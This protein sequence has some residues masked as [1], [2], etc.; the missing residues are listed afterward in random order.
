MNKK[1]LLAVIALVLVAAVF[2]GVYILTRPE[3]QVGAKEITVT[4]VHGN[5]E[6]KDFVYHT[7][8]EFLGTV[9]T[10]NNLVE[11]V[12]GPYGLEI[13][14]VDGE[15]AD[16]TEDNA[17]WS[18]Y[19]GEEYATTGADGLVIADGGHYRLVYTGA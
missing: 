15:K 17:Y 8:A 14:V 1:T 6:S 3:V 5:G 4:V 10:E 2:A 11:G 18:L 12:M 19:E 9:L 16:Y 13:K 7:D